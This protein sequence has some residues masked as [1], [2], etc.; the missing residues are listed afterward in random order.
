MPGLW[1]A[2]LLRRRNSGR[3][4]WGVDRMQK[5]R[6]TTGVQISKLQEPATHWEL[7]LDHLQVV[8]Q[9]KSARSSSRVGIELCA[10]GISSEDQAQLLCYKETGKRP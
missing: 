2:P 7:I 10:F 4:S 6:G 1:F 5:F 9:L 3:R 8:S